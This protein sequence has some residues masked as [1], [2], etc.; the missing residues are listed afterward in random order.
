MIAVAETA[1]E[2]EAL[3]KKAG[4]TMSAVCAR[5]GIPRSTWWRWQRGDHES[6]TMGTRLKLA[7]ALRDLSQEAKRSPK[8]R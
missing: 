3:A 8:V 7:E 2:L 4:V 1:A 5:A 6:P